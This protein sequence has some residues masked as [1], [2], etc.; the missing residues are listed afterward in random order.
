MK[1]MHFFFMLLALMINKNAHAVIMPN[2]S[3]YHT[4]T[5]SFN[6]SPQTE[7]LPFFKRLIFKAGLKKV[8]KQIQ[9]KKP[10][11]EIGLVAFI[12]LI[13]G[14]LLLE[15][16][17]ITGLVFSL[18]ALILTL[19]SLI[20]NRKRNNIFGILTLIL[21]IIGLLIARAALNQL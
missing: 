15:V 18:I 13:G 17:P 20:A 5:A 21:F 8:N 12:L 6:L 3:L 2:D 10:V 7:K 4:E 1:K 16:W 9:E 14:V 19:I 11:N